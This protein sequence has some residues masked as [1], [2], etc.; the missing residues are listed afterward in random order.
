MI[1]IQVYNDLQYEL[2]DALQEIVILKNEIKHLKRSK[3]KEEELL[4]Q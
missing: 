3:N 2:Q 1:N 4:N